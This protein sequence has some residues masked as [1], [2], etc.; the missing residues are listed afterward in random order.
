MGVANR[1]LFA[2]NRFV[3]SLLILL[4]ALPSAATA[5][6]I[7]TLEV[8]VNTGAAVAA[9]PKPAAKAPAPKPTA[10]K[11]ALLPSPSS[12][13][14][15]ASRGG[16]PQP[17]QTAPLKLSVRPGVVVAE[18]VV[19]RVGRMPNSRVLSSAKFEQNLAVVA[20]MDG[21]Y[22]VLM[23]NNTI[24]WI[25][26]EAIE[27]QDYQVDV[28]LAPPKHDVAP[29]DNGAGVSSALTE[30]QRQ[31]LQ[32]AFTYVGVPYVWAGNTR[33][34]LDCSAFVK[35]VF[36]TIGVELPRH[37]GHQISVGRTITDTAQLLPG[38]RL[39]FAMKGGTTITHTGIYI[40]E[41][42][43][44]HASSNHGHVDVDPLFKSYVNKL[45]AIRRDVN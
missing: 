18:T 4:A 11:A 14:S 26:K 38:D 33:S 34:G 2:D 16:R 9:A 5:Q 19:I 36:K 45:V 7:S 42:Q 41:G 32:E 22:G 44:I 35:N 13:G 25:P 3:K 20:E 27:L 8:T 17:A 29:M 28:T 43:F 15:L 31:V 39:Y 30:S 10:K 23:L 1:G 21:M 6:D 40:G 24:G 12:R 37:S